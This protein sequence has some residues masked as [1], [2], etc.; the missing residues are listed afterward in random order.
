[1]IIFMTL[2][3]IHF[4]ILGVGVMVGHGDH[5]VVGMDHFGAGIIHMLGAIG[6]GDTVGIMVIIR[7]IAADIPIEAVDYITDLNV[8][9]VLELI[10]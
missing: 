2:T 4:S 9:N 7:G 3:M 5:G 8:V 1:M 10:V 6:D